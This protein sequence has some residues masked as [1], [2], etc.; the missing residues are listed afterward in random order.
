MLKKTFFVLFLTVGII[1]AQE[2]FNDSD[3]ALFT[4]SVRA[5]IHYVKN[6]E[7]ID[8][9][10]DKKIPE[11]ISIEKLGGIPAEEVDEVIR[12]LTASDGLNLKDPRSVRIFS[13]SLLVMYY[14][15]K[16]KQFDPNYAK[17]VHAGNQPFSLSAIP[18]TDD[19]KL[20]NFI[21][22]FSIAV[23]VKVLVALENENLRKN[24]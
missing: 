11:N 23:Y 22:K 5:W 1:S 6:G 21:K 15:V 24:N 16:W 7:V 19:D 14:M 17:I 2:I 12:E 3:E 10:A 13:T 9:L 20:P 4:A 18:G 8:P